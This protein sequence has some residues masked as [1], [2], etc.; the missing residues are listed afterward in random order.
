MTGAAIQGAAVHEAMFCCG[1]LLVGVSVT[2]GATAAPTYI[3]EI[4]PPKYRVMLTG[5][6]GCSCP[7]WLIYKDRHDEAKAILVKYHGNGDP[8]ST[9][10]DIEYTE[11]CQTLEHEKCMQ[12]TNLKALVQ[13]RPNRWRIGV[14]AATGFFCQVS[15]N[16]IITYY[17][18]SVLD[19]AGIQDTKTQLGINIGMSVFNL[20]TSAVGAWAADT[21]GRRRGFLG[22]TV[23]MSLLLIIVAI[24][25]KEF[26]NNPTVSSSA[27]EVAMIF[28][29][30]GVYSLVWTPLATLYPVEVLS[31]SMRANGISF[32]SAVCYATAFL[33]TFAIPYAMNWSAWGFY[34][35]TSFWNLLV[36][37]PVMYFYFPATEN[38]TLEEI[39]IIFEGVR[40]TETTVTVRDILQG[41]KHAE[42]GVKVV[43]EEG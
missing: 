7:R 39:D 23:V 40:H 36:E 9:L 38:K 31:Y 19:A 20:F 14:V 43:E 25:T 30:F 22:S 18:S 26:G 28:L 41:G 24:I 8:Y 12:K 33:N 11:I 35:I 13:T 17:L 2:T 34:L 42:V 29:F 4:A 37:V 6:Y 16:N 15:G 10:V 1:R 27:A 32:F 21:I 3:S 5:L